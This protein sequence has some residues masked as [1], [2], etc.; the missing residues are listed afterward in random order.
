ML[1]IKDGNLRV[2]RSKP[3]HPPDRADVLPLLGETCGRLRLAQAWVGRPLAGIFLASIFAFLAVGLFDSLID[4][5]RIATLFY[6]ISLGRRLLDGLFRHQPATKNRAQ[7][8]P[9]ES[10]T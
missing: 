6:L 4:V 1:L 7:A 3:E 8:A 2:H 5:P 10:L 9:F